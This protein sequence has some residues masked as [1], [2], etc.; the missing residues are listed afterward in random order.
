MRHLFAFL[1]NQALAGNHAQTSEYAIGIEVFGRSPADCM[2]EDPVVRVQIGRLRKRLTAYYQKRLEHDGI[3]ISIP[4]GQ[5]MPVFRRRISP[6]IRHDPCLAISPIRHI[7]TDRGE[8]R[9]FAKGLYEE[10]LHR[11]FASFGGVCMSPAP[12]GP[13]PADTATSPQSRR[14][15]PSHLV[16]GSI[17]IDAERMRTSIRLVD[18]TLHCITWAEHF[19]RS[20]RYD[21]REQEDLA[22][23]ICHAL[24][25]AIPQQTHQE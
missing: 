14:A 20:V 12:S 9:A 21:I 5:Y 25:K 10:L 17:R 2:T 4:P 8:G 1:V 3:E 24:E 11:L 18:Y 6:R 23:T 19:D 15:Q 7:A 16:E 13:A 22:T